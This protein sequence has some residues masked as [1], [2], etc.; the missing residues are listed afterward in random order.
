VI[1]GMGTDSVYEFLF[2]LSR[3]RRLRL[4]GNVSPALPERVAGHITLVRHPNTY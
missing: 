2:V 3:Q 1:A 4:P